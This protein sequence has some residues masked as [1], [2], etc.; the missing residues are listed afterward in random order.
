MFYE[1]P[2][3][4]TTNQLISIQLLNADMLNLWT[5]VIPLLGGSAIVEHWNHF[6]EFPLL[7]S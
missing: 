2:T 4:K 7:L 1:C 6:C 3:L 5:P